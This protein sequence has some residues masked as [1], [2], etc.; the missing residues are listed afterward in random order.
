VFEVAGL[1]LVHVPAQAGYALREV[2]AQLAGVGLSAP[3]APARANVPGAP[4]QCPACGIP[5]VLRTAQRGPHKG[6]QFYACSNYPECKEIL[7]V[8]K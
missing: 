1:P 6:E 2:T 4:P 5:M 8:T 7:P 3:E